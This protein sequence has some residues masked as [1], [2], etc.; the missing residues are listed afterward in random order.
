MTITK[1]N[2]IEN[3]VT[4]DHDHHDK[5]IATQKFDKLMSDSFTALLKKVRQ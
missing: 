5:W 3:Q 2:E 4:T 1:S